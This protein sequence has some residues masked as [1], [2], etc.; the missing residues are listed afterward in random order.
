MNLNGINW[1]TQPMV[2]GE[3]RRF[4][5]VFWVNVFRNW[6]WWTMEHS[7]RFGCCFVHLQ[8]YRKGEYES[9]TVHDLISSCEIP[10]IHNNVSVHI[11][12]N[13][14]DTSR[15][16]ANRQEDLARLKIIKCRLRR[17]V[18]PL[19]GVYIDKIRNSVNL[20]TIQMEFLNQSLH[21]KPFGWYDKHSQYAKRCFENSVDETDTKNI[22]FCWYGWLWWNLLWEMLFFS[23]H[24]PEFTVNQKNRC[25]L[26]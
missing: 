22:W 23:W 24:P 15:T 19:F 5:S 9:M 2:F 18:W 21:T 8:H 6:W 1:I 25:S 11:P 3:T 20:K 14:N 4:G 12:S 26:H 10:F 16:I 17:T 7:I 13:S